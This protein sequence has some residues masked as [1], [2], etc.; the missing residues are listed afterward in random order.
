MAEVQHLKETLSHYEHASR[1]A[2]N[3]GK[4]ANAFS[5]NTHN[6]IVPDITSL[7]KVRKTQEEGG[8]NYV[9]FFF[10]FSF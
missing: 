8:L 1:Q 5:S 10:V 4:S 2:I 6:D 3:Y 9:S 7:L